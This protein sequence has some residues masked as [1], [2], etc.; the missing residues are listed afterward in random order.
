M[1]WNSNNLT[2]LPPLTLL[3]STPS[4]YPAER[5]MSS[6]MSAIS[7]GQGQGAKAAALI[8]D[9]VASGAWVVLQ[10]RDVL[11]CDHGTSMS[12]GE[13]IVLLCMCVHAM[14][15]GKHVAHM[16]LAFVVISL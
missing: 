2:S 14:H 3:F 11:V 5:G 4:D 15:A 8:A 6:R 9:A 12:V 10:V 16:R 7:L 1:G 13:L